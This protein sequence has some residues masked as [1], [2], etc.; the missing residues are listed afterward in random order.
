[1]FADQFNQG[2]PYFS[3]PLPTLAR[4]F[5]RG[6]RE[7]K[8]RMGKTGECYWQSM[9]TEHSA[10]KEVALEV[11]LKDGQ[12]FDR[13]IETGNEESWGGSSSA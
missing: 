13:W 2:T 4:C 1:M 9:G 8:G 10:G 12:S 6:T 5:W 11:G 3:K 7:R